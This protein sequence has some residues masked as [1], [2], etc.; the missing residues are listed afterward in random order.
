MF[1]LNSRVSE[2]TVT[3][4]RGLAQE[5]PLIAA[6]QKREWAGAD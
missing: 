6:E 1:W 2:L 5:Y 3:G 4:P